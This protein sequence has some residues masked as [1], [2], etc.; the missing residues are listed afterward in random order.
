MLRIIEIR[1][2]WHGLEAIESRKLGLL[3]YWIGLIT[4]D[5]RG[6]K[7]F[8]DWVSWWT[9]VVK[10]DW[11]SWWIAALGG[12]LDDASSSS[13][14]SW[15]SSILARIWPDGHL[16]RDAP[17]LVMA[18]GSQPTLFI[19]WLWHSPPLNLVI[20]LDDLLESQSYCR[21]WRKDWLS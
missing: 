15:H 13:I 8:T 20:V 14:A 6:C 16:L 10:T 2:Q 5:D 21:L 18:W 4:M 12:V 9:A 3:W 11:V 17:L 1:K 19:V 7:G